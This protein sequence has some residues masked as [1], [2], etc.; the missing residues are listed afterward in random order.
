RQFERTD[1]IDVGI[2]A[3]NVEVE[4]SRLVLD[5]RLL[6]GFG[7]DVSDLRNVGGERVHVGK[8][9]P[10]GRTGLLT[11]GL[12]RAAARDHDHQLGAEVGE[13]VGGGPAEA[14][15]ISQQQDDR[16]YTPSHAK[17]GEGGAPTVVLHSA[18]GFVEQITEHRISP[19]FTPVAGLPPA[20]A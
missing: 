1:G 7:S 15:A 10:Y 4:R 16:G 9:K 8:G 12:H 19:G 3:G 11:A 14:V 20:A 18:V 17:H 6:G 13:D 5:V 2:I